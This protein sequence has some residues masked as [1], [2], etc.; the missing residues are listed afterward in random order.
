MIQNTAV[1]LP[2][3]PATSVADPPVTVTPHSVE[4]EDT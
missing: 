1:S 4:A 2:T 3:C